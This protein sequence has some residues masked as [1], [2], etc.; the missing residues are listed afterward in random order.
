MARAISQ[1]EGGELQKAESKISA[2][3]GA[4]AKLAQAKASRA[5]D[6]SAERA[7]KERAGSAA[8]A[9]AAGD[10]LDPA[11]LV[12]RIKALIPQID[13]ASQGNADKLNKAKVRAIS[14][15]EGG[16]LQKAGTTITAMEGA[17]VKLAQ[18]KASRA[19]DKSAERAKKGKADEV[20]KKD[21]AS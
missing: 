2:M 14:Q 19:D 4:L 12:A 17:L 7:K 3:E 11:G 1:I 8:D 9:A 6:K 18:A 16:E 13:A 20:E 21:G 5:E 15:I 10:D